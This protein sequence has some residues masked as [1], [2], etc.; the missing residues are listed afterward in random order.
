[1]ILIAAEKGKRTENVDF[2]VKESPEY[3]G[4]F[5]FETACRRGY[6]LAFFPPTDLRVVPLLNEV[7][8]RVLDFMLVDFSASLK[9]KDLEEVLFPA[10]EP[11]RGSFIPLSQLRDC[12]EVAGY[13]KKVLQ[14]PVWDAEDFAAYFEGH[15]VD[16]EYK[17]SDQ[18]VRLRPLDER[19]GQNL[20][21]ASSTSDA[22]LAVLSAGDELAKLPLAG[23]LRAIKL[24]SA[25]KPDVETKLKS[26]KPGSEVER[27]KLLRSLPDALSAAAEAPEEQQRG[28]PSASEI[29]DAAERLSGLM[30]AEPTPDIVE[31]RRAAVRSLLDIAV[32]RIAQ[33]TEST[34]LGIEDLL[35]VLRLPA[36][37][38]HDATL[39]KACA[40][41]LAKANRASLLQVVQKAAALGCESIVQTATDA[42]VNGLDGASPEDSAAAIASLARSGSR[43]ERLAEALQVR[44]TT[45]S[46]CV[47]APAF[48]ALYERE[49]GQDALRPLAESLAAKAPW[50]GLGP[51]TLLSLA[52]AAAKVS[53]LGILWGPVAEAAAVDTQKWAVPDLVRLLLAVAR[54]KE[55]L[56]PDSKEVLLTSVGSRLAPN[57]AD[58]AV[59]ELVKVLVASSGL[60]ASTLLQAA[61]KE[62][63]IRLSD[64]SL[65]QLLLITQ[66]FAQGLA[67]NDVA[68]QQ[69]LEFWPGKLKG[70]GAASK[71]MDA[72]LSADH[73][74]KL[75]VA[76]SPI[77]KTGAAPGQA[78]IGF[79]K[80]LGRELLM[81]ALE[82]SEP[83]QALVQAELAEDGALAS[84]PRRA[85]L[86]SA[87]MQQ[88]R[89]QKASRKA[90]R[91]PS[92]GGGGGAT[93]KP[94]KKKKRRR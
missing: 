79:I 70:V 17:A 8:G 38:S 25:T 6:Y 69:L 90:S 51:E 11:H 92:P 34:P 42:A 66:G 23:A 22:T 19:L 94:S 53:S 5:R 10:A 60:G 27:L 84:F 4:A 43:T 24:L 13:F 62:V 1:V 36:A 28:F 40:V 39:S 87:L 91:S 50:S 93:A 85:E 29:L 64:L 37:A 65:P 2:M 9:Y 71:T 83:S 47:L 63:V 72:G 49:L 33:S 86:L 31:H 52:M 74:A 59:A 75:L 54:G 12:K 82:L 89:A 48:L 18:T 20:R 73:L 80:A 58:M 44:G 77:L 61:A 7:P 46:I 45:M 30:P 78:R 16:W 41:T 68:L 67:A 35:R 32:A 76:V 21:S 15:F 26:K 81:R 56:K 57:F 55:H 88:A 14:K 3:E